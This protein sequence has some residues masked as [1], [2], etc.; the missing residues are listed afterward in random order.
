VSSP[1]VAEAR[2][3][4]P[5]AEWIIGDGPHA[6]VAYC[7]VTTVMLFA[8]PAEAQRAREFIDRLACGGACV[9]QHEIVNLKRAAS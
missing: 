5:A 7:D 1:Y 6:S 2:R 4:W 3:R 9:R 8:T